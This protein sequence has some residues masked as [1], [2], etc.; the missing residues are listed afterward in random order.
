MT[1]FFDQQVS[2]FFAYL[3]QEKRLSRH[4]LDAYRRDI[5]L[6]TQFCLLQEI[7]A[8]SNVDAHIIRNFIKAQ[9]R[10]GISGR[11]LQ[12]RLSAIRTL[13]NYLIR[14]ST[15]ATNPAQGIIAAKSPRTLPN[16]LD[17]DQMAKLLHMESTDPLD[18]RDQAIMELTYSSGLRLGELVGINLHDIDLNDATVRVTGKGNRTRI[19]PIGRYAKTAILKW[20]EVRSSFATASEAAL[21]VSKR[22]R[23]IN[24]RTVQKRLSK[25][26]IIQGINTSL[27]PHMLRH[28][29]ATHLLES[30]GNLRAVQELLGHAN[31]ATTQ[32]YTHLDFQHL[33]AVYD[34]AHPRAKKKPRIA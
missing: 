19:L 15:V 27:H 34:K 23:R 24:P 4:T 33:A 31:I 25:W 3:G 14:E 21:F 5:S 11:S 30:S 17:V 18:V 1:Q 16:V 22:G 10:Q 20:L 2:F 28:S 12:R 8:W 29:F 6:F 7:T 9:H 13:F 26:A 32:I